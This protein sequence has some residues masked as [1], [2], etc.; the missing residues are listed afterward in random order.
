R[1]LEAGGK[2][3]Q[4]HLLSVLE[5][6]PEGER[7]RLQPAEAEIEPL[8]EGPGEA[9]GLGVALPGQAV[10]L[11]P[12]RVGEPHGPADLVDGLPRR[13]VPS[14]AEAA[15]DAPVHHLQEFRV[16]PGRSEEHTSELQS[17][18]NLVCRLLLEKKNTNNRV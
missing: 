15:V 2:V 12:R 4:G 10:Q 9:E 18:E 11:G 1:L 7:G 8:P 13:I 6:A 14:L 3:G 17:R 16:A 5:L